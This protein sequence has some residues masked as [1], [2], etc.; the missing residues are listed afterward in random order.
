MSGGRASS[1][2]PS[3]IQSGEA[4]PIWNVT[5]LGVEGK[6]TVGL[7]DDSDTC[8]GVGRATCAPIELAMS[9]SQGQC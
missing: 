8:S 7:C 3:M 9:R 6:E 2:L 4:T 1:S 5:G